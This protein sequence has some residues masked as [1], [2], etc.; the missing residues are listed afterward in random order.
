MKAVLSGLRKRHA[1]LGDL[2]ILIHT[3]SLLRSTVTLHIPLMR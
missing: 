3:V 1:K 2:P